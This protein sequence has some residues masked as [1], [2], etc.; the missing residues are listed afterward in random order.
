MLRA[1]FLLLA[2]LVG[3]ALL[4]IVIIMAIPRYADRNAWKQIEA[5]GPTNFFHILPPGRESLLSYSNPF[6]RSAICRFDIADQP[7]RVSSESE[8]PYWSLAIF[9]PASD[10]IYSMNDRSSSDRR[11]D[12]VI[13]TPRQMTLYRKNLPDILSD[14]VLIEYPGNEG[15]LA[16]RTVSPDPSWEEISR[17][18]LADADCS[19]APES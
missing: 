6:V 11:L 16:L 8:S 2:G 13:A 5:L 1:L 10:E 7:V 9:N 15:Y 4:H 12:V 18:F 3:A 14:A 19:P 17:Q